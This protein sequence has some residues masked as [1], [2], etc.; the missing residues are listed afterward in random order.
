MEFDAVPVSI[1]NAREAQ[2][3]YNYSV[4]SGLPVISQP[5]WKRPHYWTRRAVVGH[6]IDE[7]G[8]SLKIPYRQQN[9]L[10]HCYDQ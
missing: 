2:R 6:R 10:S 3:T 5:G 8:R 7:E 4:E 9:G 1:F